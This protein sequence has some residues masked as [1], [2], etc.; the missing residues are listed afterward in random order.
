LGGG[1]PEGE[2]S[3]GGRNNEKKRG[4]K[5]WR[6]GGK[7][8]TQR[9]L[10]ARQEKKG[11]LRRRERVMEEQIKALEER[12]QG[13]APNKSRIGESL[14]EPGWGNTS[15][16]E[17]GRNQRKTYLKAPD[18]LSVPNVRKKKK[19]KD[20]R[21]GTKQRRKGCGSANAP[22]RKRPHN[23]Q[24]L[25]TIAIHPKW[26]RKTKK[27]QRGV[28]PTRN[29]M[30]QSKG[31]KQTRKREI[32]KKKLKIKKKSRKAALTPAIAREKKA[33]KKKGSDQ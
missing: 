9:R 15:S 27:T 8:L 13:P 16:G 24:E 31:A 22:T 5:A 32:R 29:S 20:G 11:N 26:R 7:G 33:G 3:L 2:K 14:S 28:S 6:P 18:A 21:R 10:S 25:K 19:L 30:I 17:K 12:V 23:K 4:E 1:A